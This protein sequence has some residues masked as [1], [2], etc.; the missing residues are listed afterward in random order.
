MTSMADSPFSVFAPAKI[1]LFLH[2][3]GKRK[4]GYHTLDSLVAFADFG[5]RVSF[6]DAE[7]FSFEIIGPFAT[8]FKNQKG[9]LNDDNLVVRAARLLSQISGKPLNLKLS[10]IKNLPLASG[11]GGG[12]S[13][14]AAC[15]WGLQD[16]WRLDRNA[17]Y[18]APLL[19]KLGADVPVCCRCEPTVMRGI[20]EAL[21]SAPQMPEIPILLVNPNKPCSTAEVFSYHNRRYSQLVD[22]P[23]TLSNV[24]D[25]V[26]L[27]KDT[28]NDLYPAALQVVPEIENVLHSLDSQDGVLFSR[29]SGSGASC[30]GLFDTAER[31]AAAFEKI[32]ADNPDWHVFPATLNNVVRY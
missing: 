21:L 24:Y 29:M 1:N 7:S 16:F 8:Q 19:L 2:V 3:T 27:L 6:E 23:N 17:E 12:S 5:D 9:Y 18:L 4:D 26:R 22:M 30:F 25:L 10:L 13:D 11:L 28:R 14:A 15:I 31:R 32:K 20:G